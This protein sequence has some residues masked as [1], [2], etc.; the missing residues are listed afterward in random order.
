M[1]LFSRALRGAVKGELSGMIGAELGRFRRANHGPVEEDGFVITADREAVT[2]AEAVVSRLESNLNDLS[3][4]HPD[5][6]RV[7]GPGAFCN[8]KPHVRRA[9]LFAGQEVLRSRD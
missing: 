7:V 1:Q 3:F 9:Q 4:L 2:Y 5:D 6:G 8:L